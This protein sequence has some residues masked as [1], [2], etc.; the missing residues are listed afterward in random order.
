MGLCD[1]F[2]LLIGE[3]GGPRSRSRDA[4]GEGRPRLGSLGVWRKTNGHNPNPLLF[5]FLLN[6]CKSPASLCPESVIQYFSRAK[7][8][9]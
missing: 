9:W 2:P 6:A 1:T 8:L 5:L 4:R 3:A 7:D